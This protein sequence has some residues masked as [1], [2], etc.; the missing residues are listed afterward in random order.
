MTARKEAAAAGLKYYL[1]G[2]PCKYGHMSV[3]SVKDRGCV[4]CMREKVRRHA[5]NQY[6]TERGYLSVKYQSMQH[7][8][9]GLDREFSYL[10]KG[11]GIMPR[12][13]FIAWGLANAEFKVLWKA[14]QA[15]G[16]PISIAPAIDRIDTQRGYVFG[17]IQFLTV[18]ENSK[19]A[20]LWRHHGINPITKAA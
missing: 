7:R 6:R 15:Q 10:Y 5:A 1:T 19:K 18:S 11:L 17:N 13:E 9:R 20:C 12:S 3:R 16:R 8:V 4:T 2:K 14:Y